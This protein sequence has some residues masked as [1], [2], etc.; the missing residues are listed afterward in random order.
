MS[1]LVVFTQV[2]QHLLDNVERPISKDV[3]KME[4]TLLILDVE[5]R[6][7]SSAI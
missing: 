7:M 6:L 4:S 1:I 3:E 5:N 2:H